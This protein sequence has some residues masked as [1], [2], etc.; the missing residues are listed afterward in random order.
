MPRRKNVIAPNDEKALVAMEKMSVDIQK[1]R[2]LYGDGEPFEEE[3]IL[4]CIV[5]KAD[6]SSTSLSDLGRYCHWLKAE[7]G[8]GRFMAGL[9]RRGVNYFA[10]NWAMLMFDKFGSNFALV[11]NLG[12]RKARCF[13]AFTKEEI[14]KYSKGGSLGNIPHDEVANMTAT[15]LEQEV[16]RLRKKFDDQK[17]RHKKEVSEMNDELSTLRLRYAGQDMLTKEQKALAVL[18]E[19]NKEYTE[20]LAYINT[21]LRKAY[22]TVVK[23][24]KIEN[25][26][27]QQLSDWLGQ[28]YDNEIKTFRELSE[29]WINE[30]DNAGPMRDW[31]IS[32]LPKSATDL[33]AA[34]SSVRPWRKSDVRM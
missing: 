13:T 9:A 33:D 18:Q 31:R 3:R 12:T 8:H 4:D 7:V 15:E 23:A 20:T 1:A 10:A 5:F 27:V 26:N 24:E 2:E 25:V 19:L 16:R 21:Y 28:F 14:D 22:A 17:E 34:M 6:Q 30:M 29:A 11:Q 32:D